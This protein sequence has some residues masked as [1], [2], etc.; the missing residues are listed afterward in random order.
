[1]SLKKVIDDYNL[2]PKLTGKGTMLPENPK[3]LT[4]QHAITLFHRLESD[5]S[6]ENLH[7]DGE[8]T[9]AQARDKYR[10]YQKAINQLEA[11][12]FSSSGYY[13]D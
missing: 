13:L 3:A 4:E 11:L 12:G 7:C 6:P 10:M 5:L 1:M 9:P 8:I 2:W